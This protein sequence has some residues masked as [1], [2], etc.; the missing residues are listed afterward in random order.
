MLEPI[1]VRNLIMNNSLH[2]RKNLEKYFYGISTG[3]ILLIFLFIGCTSTTQ[4]KDL[5]I[6]K[7]IID[8]GAL[9]TEDLPKQVWGEAFMRDRGSSRNNSFDTIKWQL[10]TQG[11]K[12][13][14]SYYT[15]FNHGG[16]HVDAPIHMGLRGGIDSYSI[17]SFVGKLKVFDVSSYPK[18]RS[19]PKDFFIDKNIESGDIVMIYTNYSPPIDDDSYPQTVTLM[20]NAAKYLAELPVRA[21]CTDAFSVESGQ[22]GPVD[23]DSEISRRVPVHHAFLSRGIP[24]YEQL[25]NVDKLINE[26]NMFFIGPPLNIKDGDGM[27]VRP[28]V[29]VY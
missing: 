10:G 25:F 24:I 4:N 16:P 18:G 22:A 12:G 23:G 14:N 26:Q 2:R 21:F 1:E 13:S 5:I 11:D 8:L 17:E 7:E 20:P 3:S 9:I 15:L 19:I 27:I 6:P 28:I 29:L